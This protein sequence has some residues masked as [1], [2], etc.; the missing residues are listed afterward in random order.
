MIKEMIA[1]LKITSNTKM[2][3]TVTIAKKGIREVAADYVN[4]KQL[5]ST[6]ASL[7]PPLSKRQ[8]SSSSSGSFGKR[9]ALVSQDSFN[10]TLCSRCGNPHS[11]KCSM[12]PV[13][14]NGPLR[15]RLSPSYYWM[16]GVSSKQLSTQATHT[17]QS[18]LTH[19]G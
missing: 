3:H 4:R 13:W 9:I 5:M 19:T 7:P 17:N 14:T 10:I 2:V 11:G 15:Q 16:S 8:S 12:F 18:L 1:F 6:G